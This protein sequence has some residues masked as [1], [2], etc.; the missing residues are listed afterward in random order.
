MELRFVR[1]IASAFLL[2]SMIGL[3]LAPVFALGEL[4]VATPTPDLSTPTPV[5]TPT[6]VPTPTPNLSTPTPI[7]TPSLTPTPLPSI[8]PSDTTPPVISDVLEASS[9]TTDATIIWTTN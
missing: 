2:L 6:A 9:L 4:P 5:A 7:P 3:P 8:L 1:G